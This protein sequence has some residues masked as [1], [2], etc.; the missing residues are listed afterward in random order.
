MIWVCE[1]VFYDAREVYAFS[2]ETAASAHVIAQWQAIADHYLDEGNDAYVNDDEGAYEYCEEVVRA[3]HEAAEEGWQEWYSIA[4][5]DIVLRG[6]TVDALAQID[7]WVDV[8]ADGCFRGPM[9]ASRPLPSGL[10]SALFA[11]RTLS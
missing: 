1:T 9:V 10:G 7:D 11:P 8:L 2:D 6:Y 4:D 3:A 5:G